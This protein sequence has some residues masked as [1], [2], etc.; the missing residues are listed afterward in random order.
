MWYWF[1]AFFCNKVWSIENVFQEGMI[2]HCD[3]FNHTAIKGIVWNSVVFFS[4]ILTKNNNN[5]NNIII[6]IIIIISFLLLIIKHMT[7]IF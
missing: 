6:I 5:D 2:N 1:I 4:P 7:I 3:V